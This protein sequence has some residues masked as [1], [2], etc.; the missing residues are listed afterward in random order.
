VSKQ[1]LGIGVIGAWGRGQ[2]AKNAHKPDDGVRVVAGCDIDAANLDLFKAHYGP[3]VFL[4]NDVD[5]LLARPEVDAVFV[6]TP[7]Y[8]H[9]EHACKALAAGKPTYLEKPMAITVEGCDRILRTAMEHEQKLYLGHNMRH[10]TFVNEMKRLI[11]EGYIGEVK[12]AWCRHFISYGCDAYYKDWHAE[13]RY[14]T[15]L[16]LQKAAHD[17]DVMHY[18][19]GGYTT[20]TVGMGALT[21]YDK[22]TDRLEPGQKPDTSW[23]A[24]HWPPLSNTGLNPVIEVEDISML[25]MQLENG[26]MCSYQQCHFS[27]DAWRNYTIIGTEG[28][29]ENYGDYGG[30]C[31]IRLWNRRSH[32]NPEGDQRFEPTHEQGGHGGADPNI[33]AEFIRFVR[34]GGKVRT[35]PIAARNSVA[36]GYLAT[37]SLREGNVPK[38]IPPVDD[39][40]QAYFAQWCDRV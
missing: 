10:M 11:D 19:C 26:V 37:M 2:L 38:D 9:E 31:D 7:D 29:I 39:D 30:A 32:Y 6:T 34:E 35:S 24:D 16:L 25:M 8:L 18:L 17:I 12:T 40:V 3:D 22:V 20:R 5:E 1:E 36:A 28:R 27:P 4:T 15:G 21:V 33:V 14:A 13:K 23:S